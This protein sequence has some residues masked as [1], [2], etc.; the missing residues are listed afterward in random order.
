L[1]SC[2]SGCPCRCNRL[3]TGFV[4][5]LGAAQLAG[6]GVAARLEYILYPL[7]FGID[8]GLIALVGTNLGAGNY[9][10]VVRASWIAAGL[11]ALVTGCIGLFGVI[12]PGTWVSLFT[13]SAEVA[14]LAVQYLVIIGFAYPFL[15]AG[16]T[17]A[18]AF[19]AAGR[20]EWAVVGITGRVS[21]VIAGGWIA[22]HLVGGGLP[23]LAFVAGS[24]LV[25]YGAIEMVAFRAGLW[26]SQNHQRV[27]N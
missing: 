23:G 18:S 17:L 26:R 14:A 24:G 6:F 5:S 1:K 25:V 19:Q 2:A 12:T 15:G 27:S 16:L 22:I 8:A 9:P 21:V 11:A 3:F 20:P 7:T 10:R 4:G 13:D